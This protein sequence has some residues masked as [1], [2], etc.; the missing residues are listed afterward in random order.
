MRLFKGIAQGHR[1]QAGH[2]PEVTIA[3]Q[4]RKEDRRTAR[5]GV[6]QSPSAPRPSDQRPSYRAGGP[7]QCGR[8]LLPAAGRRTGRLSASCFRRS[9]PG[10]GE[11]ATTT[12]L[13][14]P[15]RKMMGGFIMKW[16]PGLCATA[17]L[18]RS[19]RSHFHPTARHWPRHARTWR[20]SFGMLPRARKCSGARSPSRRTARLWP[21]QGFSRFFA[22][23]R[24]GFPWRTL[25]APERFGL[26]RPHG[27]A[28]N[29]LTGSGPVRLCLGRL[30]GDNA[31]SRPRNFS[32]PRGVRSKAAGSTAGAGRPRRRRAESRPSLAVDTR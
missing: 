12:P 16:S 7:C 30:D 4:A 26:E 20:S 27:A 24:C 5:D 19:T 25:R 11:R 3:W 13:P 15:T 31:L 17:F 22:A 32:V 8:W 10:P 6:A 21:R 14:Y 23:S 29:R 9:A 28:P 18:A 2:D 1:Q